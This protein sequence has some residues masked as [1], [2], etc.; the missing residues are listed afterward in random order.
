MY[1]R[2]T[3]LT[4]LELGLFLHKLRGR[5]P[6]LQL[7]AEKSQHHHQYHTLKPVPPQNIDQINDNYVFENQKMTYSK[8]KKC[9]DAGKIS[10]AKAV[11]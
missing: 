7:A 3:K 8:I 1:H 4:S 6:S 5:E 2:W 11:N 10:Q 9:S